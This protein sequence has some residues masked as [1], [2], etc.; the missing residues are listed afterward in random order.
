MK[1][2]ETIAELAKAL[3]KAQAEMSGAKKGSE[4]PFLKN[5]Y[6]DLASVIH[7][8][9]EPLCNNGLSISQFP[10]THEG[11]AGVT[12]ILMHESGEFLESTLLLPC[13]KND[14]QGMGSCITYAK[15]YSYQSA[16]GIPSEDDDGNH[17]SAPGRAKPLNQKINASQIKRLK[18]IST[19]HLSTNEEYYGIINRYGFQSGKDITVDKYDAICAEIQGAS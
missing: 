13:T 12:T 19:K 15:R 16:L 4:N 11:M 10:V 5:K 3:N 2:S 17:A 7:C 14:P 9:K 1:K 18:T 6:A 8:A